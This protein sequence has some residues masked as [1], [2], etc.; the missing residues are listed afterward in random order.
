MFHPPESVAALLNAG[1]AWGRRIEI[2]CGYDEV[3]ELLR[4]ATL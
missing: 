4:R 2:L 1:A 3:D